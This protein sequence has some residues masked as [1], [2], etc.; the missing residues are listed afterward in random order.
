[1]SPACVLPAIFNE[2]PYRT[3]H[4][5]SKGRAE[6]FKKKSSSSNAKI[7]GKKKGTIRIIYLCNSLK[8]QACPSDFPPAGAGRAGH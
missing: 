7:I 3:L 6:S 2:A 5:K 4:A 1:M 8:P